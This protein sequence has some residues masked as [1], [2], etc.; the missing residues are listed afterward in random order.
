[1]SSVLSSLVAFDRIAL[2]LEVR[3]SVTILA[4]GLSTPIA[5]GGLAGDL[6]AASARHPSWTSHLEAST[7][8][9]DP[10]PHDPLPLPVPRHRSPAIEPDPRRRTAAGFHRRLSPGRL[11]PPVVVQTSSAPSLSLACGP[12]PRRRPPLSPPLVGRVGHLHAWL[13]ARSRL[14]GPTPPPPAQLARNPFFFSFPIFFSPF[15]YIY[16]YMLI[17]YAPKIV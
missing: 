14:A 8:Q 1:V 3:H 16:I 2:V 9:I 13:H 15:S 12:A 6:T 11:P 5:P 10:T 4:H 17:F 7:G